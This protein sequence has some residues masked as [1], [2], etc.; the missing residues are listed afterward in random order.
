MITPETLLSI[1]KWLQ[2]KPDAMCHFEQELAQMKAETYNRIAGKLTKNLNKLNKINSE[3]QNTEKKYSIQFTQKYNKLYKKILKYQ[4]YLKIQ[5]EAM[6]IY[7]HDILKKY[8][9]V[10]PPLPIDMKH[11]K[12]INP[13]DNNYDKG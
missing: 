9:P 5:R 8:Y 7:N 13:I 11:L 10:P 1:K 6:G 12:Y 3:Y 4:K 2:D